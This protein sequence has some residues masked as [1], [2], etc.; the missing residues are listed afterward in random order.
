[1]VVK[2]GIERFRESEK[3]GTRWNVVCDSRVER[4]RHVRSAAQKMEM[5]MRCHVGLGVVARSTVQQGTSH[6]LCVRGLVGPE[7][8]GE[9]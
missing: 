6:C 9:C 5:E 3:G 2:E 8:D 1:M 7:A 4:E